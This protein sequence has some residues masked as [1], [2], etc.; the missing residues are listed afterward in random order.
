MLSRT[1]SICR[2]GGD[3][4]R[5]DFPEYVAVQ[6]GGNMPASRDGKIVIWVLTAPK[7]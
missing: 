6:K 1:G 3:W 2:Q 5:Q 7:E 4:M